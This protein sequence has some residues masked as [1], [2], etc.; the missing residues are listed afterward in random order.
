LDYYEVIRD[1]FYYYGLLLGF[2][3]LKKG[4]PLGWWKSL[5]G[6]GCVLMLPDLVTGMPN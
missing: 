4:L 3:L 6:V 2:G 1:I 5:V